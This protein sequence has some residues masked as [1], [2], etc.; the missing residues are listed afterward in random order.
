MVC[1]SVIRFF[2]DVQIQPAFL[3]AQ[4]R[5]VAYPRLIGRRYLERLLHQI[6]NGRFAVMMLDHH[7]KSLLALR[8]NPGRL[9]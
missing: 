4:R 7:L 3:G 6:G 1:S 2:I 9:A 5:Q 8:L